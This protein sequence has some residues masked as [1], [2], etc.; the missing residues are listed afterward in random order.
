MEGRRGGLRGGPRRRSNEARSSPTKKRSNERSRAG[1]VFVRLF[2]RELTS[3]KA[4]VKRILDYESVSLRLAHIER[5]SKNDEIRKTHPCNGTE[6][7]VCTLM[8][9]KL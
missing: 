4:E 2:S 8:Y 9:K 1:D 5:I 6:P 3:V 7:K